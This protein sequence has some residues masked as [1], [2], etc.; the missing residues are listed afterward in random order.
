MNADREADEQWASP[1]HE[2][3]NAEAVS[4]SHRRYSLPRQDLLLGCLLGCA[5]GVCVLLLR[6]G[7]APPPEGLDA[8]PSR[9]RSSNL[10]CRTSRYSSYCFTVV[11][12][13]GE[14]GRRFRFADTEVMGGYYPDRP[15][16]LLH[17][18]DDTVWGIRQGEAVVAS[19]E[20]I[21]EV[22]ARSIRV[23]RAFGLVACLSLAGAASYKNN[24]H[25]RPKLACS[26]PGCRTF[27]YAS[28]AAVV[29]G[30]TGIALNLLLVAMGG[31]FVGF[32]I[33]WRGLDAAKERGHLEVRPN[34]TFLQGRLA[35][36]YRKA[37]VWLQRRIA[38]IDG[39][40]PLARRWDLIAG[41]RSGIAFLGSLVLFSL[42]FQLILYVVIAREPLD[43]AE[44]AFVGVAVVASATCL[45]AAAV[46]TLVIR[47]R[48]RRPSS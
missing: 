9:F 25:A 1:A 37:S 45:L 26:C 16:T 34:A 19:Y 24:R 43:G 40:Q 29:V 35:L 20:D 12:F 36:R 10:E 6:W 31:T 11:T 15:F 41:L 47:D 44:R 27:I 13:E 5:L 17:T 38:D 23:L 30:A 21:R 28:V 33:F 18:A 2:A 4:S 42:T 14:G 3:G 8:T 22:R 46:L 32:L 7:A 39:G 48:A